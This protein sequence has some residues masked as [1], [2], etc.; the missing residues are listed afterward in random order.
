MSATT[1]LIENERVSAPTPIPTSKVIKYGFVAE[2][3]GLNFA[4][5]AT[6]EASHFIEDTMNMYY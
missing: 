3:T 1:N 4:Y 2:I 6:D 5:G